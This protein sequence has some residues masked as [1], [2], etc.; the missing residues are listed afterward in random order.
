MEGPP[1]LGKLSKQRLYPPFYM[2]YLTNRKKGYSGLCLLHPSGLYFYSYMLP[3][4][5]ITT[6]T[7]DRAILSCALL[8]VIIIMKP[9]SYHNTYRRGCNS[10]SKHTYL[11]GKAPTNNISCKFITSSMVNASMQLPKADLRLN[12]SQLMFLHMA[13]VKMTKIQ[14]MDALIK[15]YLSCLKHPA[16]SNNESWLIPNF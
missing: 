1:N 15:V 8:H 3:V 4:H 16:H 13:E 10:S 6:Q 9:A 11:V 14:R 5:V 7:T 2:L 12:I